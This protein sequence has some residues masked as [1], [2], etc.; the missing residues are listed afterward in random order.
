VPTIATQ[1]WCYALFLTQL[2]TEKI[3]NLKFIKKYIFT[4]LMLLTI[5]FPDDGSGTSAVITQAPHPA[6]KVSNQVLLI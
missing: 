3:I 5:S 6:F 1:N 4:E 2:I